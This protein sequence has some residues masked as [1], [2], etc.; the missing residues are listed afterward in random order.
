MPLVKISLL[1][2]RPAAE[3]DAISNAI[4]DGLVKTLGVPTEDFFQLINEYEPE[5][6]RHTNGFLGLHYSDRLLILEI[7]FLEGRADTMKKELI[8]QINTNLV[9]A[10]VVVPDDVFIMIYEIG[11]ANLSFGAGEAQRAL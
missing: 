4:Q 11:R 10:A 9:N 3:K 5:S 1:A 2:G 6:F 8:Q 7:T